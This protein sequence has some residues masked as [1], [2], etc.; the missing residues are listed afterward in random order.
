M[1]KDSERFWKLLEP[2]H[3]QA[4][5]F[6]RK[7]CGNRDDG[8]DLYQEALLTALRQI[9]SLRQSEN[10]RPWLYRIIVNRFKNRTR[11]P[12]WRKRVSLDD[13]T[14]GALATVNPNDRHTARRWLERAMAVLKPEDRALVVLY[15]IDGWKVGELAAMLSKPDG[16]VKARLARSR[17][18]MR[19]VLSKFMVGK[20]TGEGS[21]VLPEN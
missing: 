20:T 15:E 5:S 12:W 3:P 18:K 16:T 9:T 21:Y 11:S 6:C 2:H 1:N 19:R 17:E 14:A 7:L 13:E 8:D 10:F 4:E